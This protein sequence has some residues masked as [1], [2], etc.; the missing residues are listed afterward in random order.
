MQI[1]DSHL[2][3]LHQT[4]W[5]RVQGFVFYQPSRWF[6]ECLNLEN[7]RF[8]FFCTH[9]A[10]TCLESFFSPLPKWISLYL[11]PFEFYCLYK[12]TFSNSS[13]T[14]WFFI[15]SHFPICLSPSLICI[16]IVN[17]IRRCFIPETIILLR[18]YCVTQGRQM[19]ST[20]TENPESLQS[21]PISI[22]VEYSKQQQCQPT[23]TNQQSQP[24]R[25]SKKRKA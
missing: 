18:I 15:L 21:V 7:H 10:S 19:R 3:L 2:D 9:F 16:S 8:R 20:G 14:F 1:I 13:I 25:C 22:F 23:Q 6:W 12:L 4:L 17:L 5:G 24:M 11:M